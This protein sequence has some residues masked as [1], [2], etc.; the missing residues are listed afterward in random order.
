[1]N[2]PKAIDGFTF[3]EVIAVLVI[4]VIISAVVIS[5]SG[6]FSADL[7]SQTEILK[8][9]LRYAQ[10][11]GMSGTDSSDV[12]GM[13]CD[14]AF[15]W[16]FKGNDPDVNIIMLPDDQRY[17]TGNGKL[18]LAVK[19]IAITAFT[20]FFDQRGIPYSSYP[21]DTNKVPYSE[22]LSI[23]VTKAGDVESI[24]VTLHTGFI[25]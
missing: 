22:D 2:H 9:H 12:F 20:V 4:V 15:Y 19:K 21:D 1:M 24:T 8:N 25:P 5:K 13:K 16:M 11:L 14:T 17:N 18:D 10:T 23:T 7:V 6:S 3:V